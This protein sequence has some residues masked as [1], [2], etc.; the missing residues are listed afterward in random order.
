MNPIRAKSFSDYARKV[1]KETIIDTADYANW[2]PYCDYEAVI[3]KL[4]TRYISLPARS[5]IFIF[6]DI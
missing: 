3:E 2:E 5:G 1:A 4:K 6:W